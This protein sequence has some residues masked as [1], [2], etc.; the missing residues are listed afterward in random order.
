MLL[1][2]LRAPGTKRRLANQWFRRGAAASRRT[3]NEK[4]RSIEN[5]R[6]SSLRSVRK[7]YESKRFIAVYAQQLRIG[8]ARSGE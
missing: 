6:N 3:L 4:P 5:Q 1:W 2:V 7:M 8:S